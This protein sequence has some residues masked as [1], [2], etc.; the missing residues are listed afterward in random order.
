[1]FKLS[2]TRQVARDQGYGW[3]HEAINE[4]SATPMSQF[5]RVRDVQQMMKV[6]DVDAQL[7]SVGAKI[8]GQKASKVDVKKLDNI[9]NILKAEIK[10]ELKKKKDEVASETKQA[11]FLSAGSLFT[12]IKNG[13]NYD[14]S[15][16]MTELFKVLIIAYATWKLLDY[17]LKQ[18]AK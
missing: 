9:M 1:M 7:S 8:L 6:G 14:V 3:L 17:S 2:N 10:E 11:G 13:D 16:N 18:L 15:I 4:T 12:V 5:S